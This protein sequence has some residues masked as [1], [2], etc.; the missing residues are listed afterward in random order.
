[1]A[2]TLGLSKEKIFSENTEWG[3]LFG[4]NIIPQEKIDNYY[5]SHFNIL[6]NYDCSFITGPISVDLISQFPEY[7]FIY[8]YRDPRDHLNSLY[9]FLCGLKNFQG[10]QD[11]VD[12]PKEEVMLRLTEGTNYV[13][14]QR[15]HCWKIPSLSEM[16][17]EYALLEKQENLFPLKF[18]D[19]RYQPL[20]AYRRLIRWLEFDKIDLLPFPDEV[21]NKI[22]QTGTFQAQSNGVRKDGDNLE[23]ADSVSKSTSLN[24]GLRKGE[25]GDWKNHFSTRVKSKFKSDLGN[26][27]VTLNYESDSD[28]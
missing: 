13:S 8:L 21:L 16:A 11:L 4:G 7:K 15:D 18:E 19:A 6:N 24:A 12:Q 27:L 20:D 28:W 14:I 17:K 23:G 22:V 26:L 3:P 2:I 25:H 1:M 5:K 10:F 9:H